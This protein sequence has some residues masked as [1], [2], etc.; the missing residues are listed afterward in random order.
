MVLSLLTFCAINTQCMAALKR[1]ESYQKVFFNWILGN[2][3]SYEVIL[4]NNNVLPFVYR[5]E[6]EPLTLLK[7]PA[8]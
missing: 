6:L 8:D 1:M 3:G 4:K 5:L 7:K 2:K